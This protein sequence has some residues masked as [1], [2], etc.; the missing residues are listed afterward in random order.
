MFTIFRRSSTIDVDCFTSNN[1]AY[2]FTP[3]VKA[4]KAKP[5]WYDK[6]ENIKPSTTTK[7]P[8]YHINDLG[9]IDFDWKPS[10]RTVKSCP[11][12]H[13]LYS[14]G[15]ILEN[16]CDFVVNVNEKGITYHYSNGKRPI[17]HSNEQVS[18]GFSNFHILKLNSPWI[19]QTKEDVPFIAL[20]AQWSLEKFDFH[21]LP[22][23]VNFYHQTGSNVFLTI[24]KDIDDQFLIPMGQ[25]LMQ[26]IPLTDKKIKIHNHIV[27][28]D[29]LATKT[30]N[31]TGTSMGWR[32]T[33]AL[34]K[35]NDGRKSKCPFGFGD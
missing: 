19:I 1:Y 23:I 28:E 17:L 33:K 30:Y 3:V 15:F 34:I 25:P 22:G 7:W 8:Q 26:F 32:R 27:S 5:E 29:E 21:I 2:K 4:S 31:V 10:L 12:F 13:E 18:P 24:K 14:K 20:S 35:R 16:W 11:G 9:C 6:V